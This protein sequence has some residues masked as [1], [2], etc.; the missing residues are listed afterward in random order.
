[1]STSSGTK[2]KNSEPSYKRDSR[3]ISNG[4]RGR[5][6]DNDGVDPILRAETIATMAFADAARKNLSN[7]MSAGSGSTTTTNATSALNANKGGM[8]CLSSDE[9]DFDY[10]DV[11]GI[12]NHVVDLVN[13]PNDSDNEESL[14]GKIP[15][16]PP[17]GKGKKNKP[18]LNQLLGDVVRV[19]KDKV[20]SN[21]SD[22]NPDS[23]SSDQL[24]DMLVTVVKNKALILEKAAVL[25]TTMDVANQP[26]GTTISG[27][28]AALIPANV[29]KKIA[30]SNI[31]A[32]LVDTWSILSE[33]LTYCTFRRTEAHDLQIYI[34]YMSRV[35]LVVKRMLDEDKSAPKNMKSINLSSTMMDRCYLDG[36]GFA[37]PPWC[38][39]CCRCGHKCTD[40]PKENK[41]ASKETAK[42]QRQWCADNEQVRKYTISQGPPLLNKKGNVITNVPP[43]KFLPEYIMC[44]CWQQMMSYVAAGVS[45]CYF[46][47]L[48]DGIQYEIGKCPHCKCDCSFVV[49]KL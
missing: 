18:F 30:K 9:S 32:A 37:T 40:Q 10:D 20:K 39:M 4:E 48:V 19:M 36:G 12:D 46:K 13:G 6:S 2:K 5:G 24:R 14:R 8:L 49:D 33:V 38:S 43:P 34:Q 26:V 7:A 41:V 31:S 11:N 23:T 25:D 16:I 15:S 3:I 28:L 22:G 27:L 21:Y 1:M 35:E 17:W 44:H 29:P 45:G 47:C 42:Y